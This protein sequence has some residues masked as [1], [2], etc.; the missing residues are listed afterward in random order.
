[1]LASST[2]SGGIVTSGPLGTG[3]VNLTG[4]L[5]Q[6]GATNVPD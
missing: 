1:V 2:A 5:L 3:A 6:A 4:G